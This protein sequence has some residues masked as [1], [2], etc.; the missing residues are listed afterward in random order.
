MQEILKAIMDDADSETF[1]NLKIPATYRAAHILKSEETIFAGVASKF[2]P[3]IVTLAPTSAL[4]GLK[5][6]MVGT[7]AKTETLKTIKETKSKNFL[8][9]YSLNKKNL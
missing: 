2:V 6:V 9:G 5:L 1:A 3:V 7:W 8:I 4:A